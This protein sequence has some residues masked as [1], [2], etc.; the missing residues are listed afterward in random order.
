MGF[1]AGIKALGSWFVGGSPN[2][3]M[4]IVKDVGKWIDKQQYTDQEKAE[5]AAKRAEAYYQFM[6]QTIQENS[7]R[8]K[9]R[10]SLALLVLRWW[11][12]ML[13]FSAVLFKFDQSWSEYVFRVATYQDVG[14]MVLGI[15]AFFWGSHLIRTK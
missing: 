7:D 11:V 3:G 9:T 4:E 14:W 1:L 2:N 6:Q 10:R 15:G 5:A 12:M 8:S 13:T